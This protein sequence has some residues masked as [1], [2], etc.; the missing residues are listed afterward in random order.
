[1]HHP[2]ISFQCRFWPVSVIWGTL[3][4]GEKINCSWL[5][6]S[7]CKKFS[8]KYILS[9]GPLVVTLPVQREDAIFWAHRRRLCHGEAGGNREHEEEEKRSRQMVEI[10][11]FSQDS[12]GLRPIQ[13]IP[14]ESLIVRRVDVLPVTT[15]H[16]DHSF[17]SRPSARDDKFVTTRC[18]D[19]NITWPGVKREKQK[20]GSFNPPC[21]FATEQNGEVTG[22][23]PILYFQKQM[24]FFFT[25][26]RPSGACGK[27]ICTESLV[28]KLHIEKK[29]LAPCRNHQWKIPRQKSSIPSW[30][31]QLVAENWF[32]RRPRSQFVLEQSHKGVSYLL[33][34]NQ[35]FLLERV[36]HFPL[37]YNLLLGE[38]LNRKSKKKNFFF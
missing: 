17:L 4:D 15:T 3:R 12:T 20:S 27:Q 9:I 34:H 13:E 25:A 24:I 35:L 21:P 2:G 1:M 14:L 16:C 7:K 26:L 28:E 37:S 19:G 33:T 10:E 11:A 32:L 22:L 31:A 29:P 8:H 18:D 30:G 36:H 5:K 6:S 23:S 38:R